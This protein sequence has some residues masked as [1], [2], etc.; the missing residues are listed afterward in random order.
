MITYLLLLYISHV[1]HIQTVTS[2]PSVGGSTVRQLEVTNSDKGDTSLQGLLMFI[3]VMVGGGIL[4]IDEL[5]SMV[6]DHRAG[7]NPFICR[8][9]KKGILKAKCAEF[10]THGPYVE[11]KQ[12]ITYLKNCLRKPTPNEEWWTKIVYGP[13][14]SGKTVAVRE[15][16]KD[17]EAVVD[18]ILTKGTVDEFI[19]EVLQKVQWRNSRCNTNSR[20]DMLESALISM[21]DKNPRVVPTLLIKVTG[22]YSMYH[23]DLSELLELLKLWVHKR[24]LANAII[25]LSPCTGV[26]PSQLH[27]KRAQ[28]VSIGDLTVEETKEYLLG[29]CDYKQLQG[30]QDEK[31]RLAKELAPIA[32]GRLFDLQQLVD[33]VPKG[34]T[35]NDLETLVYKQA[36]YLTTRNEISLSEFLKLFE[37]NDKF[38]HVLR[39]VLINEQVC[40]DE[41]YQ[42]LK[43]PKDETYPKTYAY[44]YNDLWEYIPK[45][46]SQPIYIN[47]ETSEVTI[48]SPF[49]RKAI[50]KYLSQASS[51]QPH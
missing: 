13:C 35:L 23:H 1:Y 30:S 10:V 39:K 28:V 44:R 48:R 4:A 41:F 7:L 5:H 42:C 34:G 8:K 27:D 40:L 16:L 14:K 49:M 33:D 17:Q 15:V 18:V 32:G 24:N 6:M 26:C 9:I 37:Q 12:L 43:K 20:H 45:I 47:P 29:I 38:D 11:R 21:R 19:A 51:K 2:Q 3:M 46:W 36:E 25:V 50:E 22:E 31:G